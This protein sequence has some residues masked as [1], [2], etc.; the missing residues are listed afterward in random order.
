[1][2]GKGNQTS[3]AAPDPLRSLRMRLSATVGPPGDGQQHIIL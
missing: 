1:L 3:E 2:I